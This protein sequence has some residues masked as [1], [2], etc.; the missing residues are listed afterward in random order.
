MGAMKSILGAALVAALAISL[1]I[2]ASAHDKRFKTRVT[3]ANPPLTARYE[4]DVI[5]QKGSCVR[6]RTVEFWY[7]HEGMPDELVDTITATREG[8]WSYEFI[9]DAYYARVRRVVK[10]PGDHKHICK[11]DRSPTV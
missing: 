11:G 10:K 2:P 9:G 1:A 3:I 8:H 7:D 6:Y 5:S 4:G